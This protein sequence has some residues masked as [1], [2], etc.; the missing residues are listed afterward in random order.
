MADVSIV[1]PCYNEAARLPVDA[2][3]DHAK[4]HPECDFVFVDDGSRDET[5]A[6]IRSLEE[7]HPQQFRAIHQPSNQGKAEAVRVGMQSAFEAGA[8]IA[9]YWDADLATP[10]FEIGRMQR[11]LEREPGIEMVFGSRVQLLGRDIRRSA[12]RHYLGRIFATA[13]SLSLGLPIYDTQCGAK[14][15]RVSATTRA[16]FAEPFSSRWV[17]DVELIARLIAACRGS[18]APGA[19]DLIYELPLERWIDVP[20]SKVR[21]VDFVRAL[22][23]MWRIHRRYLVNG[24]TAG[25]A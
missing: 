23:E 12:L 6:L 21:P 1:I 10:L 18:N 20:G 7:R 5:L 15:F 25:T 16:L 13:A 8:R 22:F 2:F 17:F 4:S 24:R 11:V 14:L 3:L 9:G 19:A